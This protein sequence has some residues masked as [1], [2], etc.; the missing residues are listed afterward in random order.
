MFAPGRAQ[1]GVSRMSNNDSDSGGG[2]LSLGD[3]VFYIYGAIYVFILGVIQLRL[4]LFTLSANI[5]TGLVGLATIIIF[6]IIWIHA[7]T[8]GG[9]LW[10]VFVIQPATLIPQKVGSWKRNWQVRARNPYQRTPLDTLSAVLHCVGRQL[11]KLSL[12]IISLLRKAV[13][14][15]TSLVEAI[16]TDEDTTQTTDTD[17]ED[18]NE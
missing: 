4:G 18:S 11:V 13:A 14:L 6:L 8:V 1:S 9:W 5:A 7:D 3:K 12:M 10:V 16:Q 17:T 15:I 2:G